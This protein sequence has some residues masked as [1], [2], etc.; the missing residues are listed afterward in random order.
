MDPALDAA[1]SQ[2][3]LEA[4]LARAVAHADITIRKYMWRGFRPKYGSNKQILAGSKSADDFVS[5]AIARLLDGK[6]SYDASK[7]LIENINSITDSLI[8]SAKKS[9]DR[10]G[11]VDYVE[12][13]TEEGSLSDPI[14]RAPSTDLTPTEKLVSKELCEDQHRCFE[15][16]RASFNGDNEMREYLEALSQGFF[17][18]AEIREVTGIEIERIYELRRKLIAYAPKFFGVQSF[19]DF[20]RVLYEGKSK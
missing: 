10:S 1:F 16:L 12:K 11:V 14:S 6:R 4:T 9:S 8:W 18:P 15:S 19:E 13:S 7:T 3:D 20:A 17:K 2:P 5:E